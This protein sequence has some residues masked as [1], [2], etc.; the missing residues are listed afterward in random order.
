M[1]WLA[2]G[3]GSD[4]FQSAEQLPGP[5]QDALRTAFS[6]IPGPQQDALRTAFSG[7]PGAHG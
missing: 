7:I 2:A 3:E 4:H 6:G 1:P 5:Q